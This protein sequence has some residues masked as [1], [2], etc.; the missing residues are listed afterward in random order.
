MQMKQIEWMNEWVERGVWT[1]T[2]KKLW[3]SK[4]QNAKLYPPNEE[5][6]R[7]KWAQ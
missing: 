2:K 1:D 7:M 4:N 6:K 5:Y 3:T